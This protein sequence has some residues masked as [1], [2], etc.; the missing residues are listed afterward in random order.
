M[1][2]F[3]CPKCGLLSTIT[4]V[5]VAKGAVERYR[6]CR[7][8]SINFSTVERVKETPRLRQILGEDKANKLWPAPPFK[9]R[10]IKQQKRAK[11]ERRPSDIDGR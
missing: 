5:A 9:Y 3:V 4:N 2:K 10:T 7:I 1:T 8:C 6:H 11:G